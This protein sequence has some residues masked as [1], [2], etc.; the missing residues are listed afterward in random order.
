MKIMDTHRRAPLFPR[1]RSI[2]APKNRLMLVPAGRQPPGYEGKEG[3]PQ[4]VW[5]GLVFFT[6]LVSRPVSG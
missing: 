2:T 4:G 1:G 3:V 5:L 6:F